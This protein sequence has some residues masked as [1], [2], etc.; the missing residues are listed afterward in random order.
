MITQQYIVVVCITVIL[1]LNNIS[2]DTIPYT[3][4]DS[5]AVDR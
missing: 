4:T 1:V 3:N 5:V 2:A